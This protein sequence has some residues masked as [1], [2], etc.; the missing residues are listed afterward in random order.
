MLPENAKR[1][2]FLACEMGNVAGK[3]MEDGKI[4]ISD[5]GSLLSLVDELNGLTKVEWPKVLPEVKAAFSPEEYGATIAELAAKFDIPQDGIE[6]KLEKSLSAIGHVV[7]GVSE[8][9][10]AW[11]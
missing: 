4:T 2:L 1:V 11:K 10:A 9:I 7:L 5:A 8:L 3:I 6:A